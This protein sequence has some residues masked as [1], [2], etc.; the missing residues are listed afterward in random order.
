MVVELKTVASI[1]LPTGKVDGRTGATIC[2]RRTGNSETSP[3]AE[4]AC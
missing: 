2:Q 3:G 4:L 1:E